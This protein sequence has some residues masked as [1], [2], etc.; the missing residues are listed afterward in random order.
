[1]S[2][3]I[4]IKRSICTFCAA[5]CGVLVHVEKGKI[6][7]IEGNRDHPLSQGYICERIKYAIKW[8]Y[9]PDQLHYPLKRAGDRGE[10][11]WERITW[12]QA[13]D[14]IAE[15][16]REL[17]EQYGPETLAVTEG[18]LRG[19]LFWMRSRFCYLFGNPHKHC[20]VLDRAR[21]RHHL[22]LFAAYDLP[23]YTDHRIVFPE[24]TARRLVRFQDPHRI[25]NPGHYLYRIFLFL[26]NL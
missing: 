24:I 19:A 7:K 6:I 16:L 1:M 11:K 2:G 13:L 17:K 15:K 3:G 23:L 8:L 21:P 5:N 26:R 22:Y 10:N 12:D 14:E 20:L 4:E 9:H 25:L 18:T